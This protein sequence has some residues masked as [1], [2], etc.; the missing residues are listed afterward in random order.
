[1]AQDLET[2]MT[3]GVVSMVDTGR[4]V[5]SKDGATDCFS[6]GVVCSDCPE[7]LIE[8]HLVNPVSLFVAFGITLLRPH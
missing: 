1:M 3:F 6:F 2:R 5:Q 8:C 7:W 4:I